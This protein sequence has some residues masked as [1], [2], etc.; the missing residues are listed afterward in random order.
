[1]YLLFSG[2]MSRHQFWCTA[3]VLSVLAT[4]NQTH[5]LCVNSDRGEDG[6]S[7]TM[8]N[9]PLTC[10]KSL[11]FLVGHL[12]DP[13]IHNVEINIL[14]DTIL[15]SVVVFSNSENITIQSD[16]NCKITCLN[17]N[18]TGF[19]FENVT[20]LSMVNLTIEGCG[21]LQNS[22]THVSGSNIQPMWCA[23]FV[24]KST[25]LSVAN[26]TIS[27]S[28]G[29]GLVVYDTKG[30]VSISGSL[31]KNNGIPETN[32]TYPGGG[33]LT[34]EI[35]YSNGSEHFINDTTYMIEDCRFIGN[36]AQEMEPENSGYVYYYNEVF[37]GHGRGGGLSL[38]MRGTTSNNQAYVT[39]CEFTN[40]TASTW[41]G[42]AYVS[43]RDNPTRNA[44][45]FTGCTFENNTC[46]HFGGGGAKITILSYMGVVEN[47]NI[48][49]STC[50]F[51]SNRAKLNGGGLALVA[52]RESK[53]KNVEGQLDNFIHFQDCTFW[54][55]EATW[56]SAVD[57]SPAHWD[58]LGNGILPTPS[59]SRCI[60]KDNHITKN[61]T[62]I[63][64]GINMTTEGVGTFL[65]SN[66][67]VCVTNQLEFIDNNGT[68]LY[69]QS[70]VIKIE[71]NTFVLFSGNRAREGGA[72]GLYSFS[73]IF[74]S[75][76]IC[77]S[78]IGNEAESR[79]GAVYAL[80][81]DEHEKYSSRSCF[82]QTLDYNLQH[83]INNVAITFEGNAARVGNSIFATSLK[84]CASIFSVNFT[85]SQKEPGS[86]K[87]IGLEKEDVA[88]SFCT[89]RHGY[90]E[91]GKD[92][93]P[94]YRQRLSWITPGQFFTI[95]IQAV[96]EL[97]NA[98][99]LVYDVDTVFKNNSNL[100]KLNDLVS[101]VSDKTIRL[102]S[103]GKVV[104]G[105]ILLTSGHTKLA[106]NVTVGRCPPGHLINRY[107]ICNCDTSFFRGIWKCERGQKVASIINGYWIGLCDNIQC[108]GHCPVGFCNN[109]ISTALKNVT[110]RETSKLLCI[111]NREGK[112]C[113]RCAAN[114]SVFYHSHYFSCGEDLRC[115]FGILLYII[116]E[117]LPLTVIF[118]IVILLNISFTS[119]AIN[120]VLLYAQIFDSFT[121]NFHNIIHFPKFVHVLIKGYRVVYTTSNLNYFSIEKF[122]FCLW[123]G[124]TTLDVIA[125]KYVTIVYALCLV[126]STIFLLN[127][128]ACK[129]C[130]AC[131]RPHTV[132]NAAIHGIV[133]FLVMCYSECARVSFL[134]L[135]R[136]KLDGGSKFTSSSK[137]VVFMSGEHKLFD[138]V[139]IKYGIPALFFMLVVVVLPP[140]LLFLY[141]LC[142]KVLALCRL[143]ELKIVNKISNIIPVQLFDSFQSCYKDELR[144]FSGLYFFYRVVPLILFAVNTDVPL[145]YFS[146]E[147][148][149]LVALA[150]NATLQPYKN[151]WHNIIDILIFTNL[152][153]I[154]AISLY[155]YQKINEGKNNMNVVMT[156]VTV[157]TAFQLVLIYLPLV[158]VIIH[159]FSLLMKWV[160]KKMRERKIR[161]LDYSQETLLD[162]MYLP[163]LRDG[164]GSSR[165]DFHKMK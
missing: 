70:A 113:G 162:S 90:S 141:P 17:S 28:K 94:T 78:F 52:T 55:N 96:D 146:L 125:W 7:C 107:N 97:G 79:G 149:L 152:A 6:D 71:P 39:N 40:N 157:T 74:V 98:I 37:Q 22:S 101:Y 165:A 139:H 109:N 158:F 121:T 75:S 132:K 66:F 63:S 102:K 106:V 153:I 57:I 16:D 118:I 150:L 43:L 92:L 76:N 161:K 163:P 15:D 123:K 81:T 73:V 130:C 32:N 87:M 115:S 9:Q 60:F 29:T 124:A 88:T 93:G 127:T 27:D 116:S 138:D 84:P 53:L 47:N 122:S 136:V 80:S 46:K 119:G 11:K 33:G 58:V 140:V 145:Y 99:S 117:I 65:I 159:C 151:S 147:V 13:D 103:G 12:P 2:T 35:T 42:G 135:T 164:N 20:G 72:V 19:Y 18:T 134:L 155:N 56:G 128:T 100:S 51:T 91:N 95:P 126:M 24:I 69:L 108:S 25:D 5:S 142:F 143:S 160:S 68:A 31:F 67:V 54:D 112:L 38:V 21:T 131:W 41:G 8:K 50:N 36:T 89:F 148:F 59:F 62:E 77:I 104:E 4:L 82:I 45:I 14:Q 154:N 137:N 86:I 23:I 49:F 133:A 111:N 83:E 129:K 61:S 64:P 1:M 156:A 105:Q 3:V 120:G 85:E 114:H 34:I 44:I 110:I 30:M 26:V 10:C 48:S 144:F